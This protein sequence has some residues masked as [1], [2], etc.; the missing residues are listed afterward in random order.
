P[1]RAIFD[2]QGKPL[3]SWRVQIL[4]FLDQEELYQQFRLDE[5]WDSEH[6]KPLIDKMPNVFS[7]PRFDLPPGKTVY[8]AVVGPGTAFDGRQGLKPA[9]IIDGTS[10][11]IGVVEVGP[12]HAV[13]WTKPVD[14]EFDQ[15]HPLNGLANPSP[16]GAYGVVLL[17]GRVLHFDASISA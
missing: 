3:L 6:N 11:T 17:D 5:P 8:Q 1:P 13:P 16:G 4:P 7:D 10:N 14:W 9:Q 15:D 2:D 12:E